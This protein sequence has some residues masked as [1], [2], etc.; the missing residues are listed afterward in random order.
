VTERQLRRGRRD[1]VHHIRRAF[2]AQDNL[3]HYLTSL[4]YK[5]RSGV[6]FIYGGGDKRL[7]LL[8]R[9]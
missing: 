1:F 8:G 3:G 9:L 4:G 7:D 5:S 6:H 2:N